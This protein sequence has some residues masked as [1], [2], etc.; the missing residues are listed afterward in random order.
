MNNTYQISFY[1]T[2][3]TVI[4]IVATIIDVFLELKIIS[5]YGFEFTTGAFIFPLVYIA[6]DCISEIYGYKRAI[7][8]M[9]LTLCINT[10]VILVFQFA[11]WIPA[12]EYWE[13]N[14]A[15]NNIFG[16]AP[17]LYF[18]SV[19]SIIVGSVLNSCILTKMKV[20]SSG[21]FFKFRAIVSSMIARIC[22][23]STF[24]TIAYTGVYEFSIIGTL[25]I[26]TWMLGIFYE[27]FMLPI[28]EKIV[29]YIKKKEGIDFFDTNTNYN[30]LLV[31]SK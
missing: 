8:T 22:E 10:I 17:R 29:T 23:I 16:M 26:N 20:A 27:L 24:F 11:C 12:V 1:Y 3:L 18:A 5:F 6:D 21:K 13:L 28:T 9:W 7:Q 25:I 15:F 4:L 30:P 19:L 14:T 2:L 31:F